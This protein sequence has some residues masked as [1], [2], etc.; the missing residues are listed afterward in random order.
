[1]SKNQHLQVGEIS[2]DVLVANNLIESFDSEVQA[3]GA[4]PGL[5]HH[6]K[7]DEIFYIQSGKFKINRGDEEIV[8]TPGMTVH[9]PKNTPHGWKALEDRSRLLVT[10]IPGANQ[11][12][13]LKELGELSKSG[14]S[15]K[16]GITELQKKYDCIPL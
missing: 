8:A 6:T 2:I 10:F 7:M 9:V 14:A 11:L 16:E 12:M 3:E 15:W 5:H 13:Y 4:G 1:M